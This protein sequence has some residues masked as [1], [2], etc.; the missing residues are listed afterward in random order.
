VRPRTYG[1]Q[2]A[3]LGQQLQVMAHRG[4]GDFLALHVGHVAGGQRLVAHRERAQGADAER[5]REHPERARELRVG[6]GAVVA[7][8]LEPHGPGWCQRPRRPNRPAAI[9][10]PD[11]RLGATSGG[12]DRRGALPAAPAAT[13][14]F[15]ARL[16]PIERPMARCPRTCT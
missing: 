12:S 3:R 16:T 13:L 5:M 6:M 7:A 9:L 1:A 14:G 2:E 11:G 10:A 15:I 4:S 8:L